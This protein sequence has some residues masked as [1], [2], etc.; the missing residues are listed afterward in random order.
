M[1][2]KGLILHASAGQIIPAQLLE[3]VYANGFKNASGFMAV[4]DNPTELLVEGDA[5]VPTVEE[6]MNFQ[7]KEHKDFP[8]FYTFSHSDI[9]IPGDS[10]QPF[11]VL[12]DN[13]GSIALAGA[14][15]GQFA[16]YFEPGPENKMTRAFNVC[17]QYIRPKM[18]DFYAI[19]NGDIDALMKYLAE[20][21]VARLDIMNTMTGPAHIVLL[22][23]NGKFE[24]FTTV[25]DKK[26]HVWGWGTELFDFEEKSSTEHMP[27]T[28]KRT[29]MFGKVIETV[30]SA[31]PSG[32]GPTMTHPEGV[33]TVPE[34]DDDDEGTVPDN[35]K[36]DPHVLLL[37]SEEHLH[38]KIDGKDV[39]MV[40]CPDKVKGRN[41]RHAWW[42]YN[43]IRVPTGY[44]KMGPQ[45]PWGEAN[46]T[47]I[48]RA[49]SEQTAGSKEVYKAFT[50][51]P[52]PEPAVVPAPAPTKTDPPKKDGGNNSPIIT[53]ASK[54]SILE[55][56]DS[57]MVKGLIEKSGALSQK[58][59]DE[60]EKANTPWSAQTEYDFERTLKWPREVFFMMG[61]KSLVALVAYTMELRKHYKTALLE[62]EHVTAPKPQVDYTPKRK[63]MFS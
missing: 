15:C 33:H 22:G 54:K 55:M 58:E 48:K 40:K 14:F 12:K 7:E 50:D 35:S 19:C 27:T 45:S 13:D 4:V 59:L 60:I 53:P 8:A 5:K 16:S 3:R 49:R 44:K 46:E 24:H 1:A 25:T 11:T 36:A 38:K 41:N 51:L 37:P 39:L 6:F 20:K 29:S 34:K 10:F 26:E 2:Y 47:Y 62:M 43:G 61:N 17:N 31:V 52:K 28:Q 18:E 30:K 57:G 56:L 23:K 32:K 42:T 21:Q 63:S 9:P